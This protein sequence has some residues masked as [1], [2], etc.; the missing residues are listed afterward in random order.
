MTAALVKTS[1]LYSLKDLLRFER[2]HSPKI[3]Q[4]AQFA[5]ARRDGTFV[6]VI[7]GN[8]FRNFDASPYT[9]GCLYVEHRIAISFA[10]D[11]TFCRTSLTNCT[12]LSEWGLIYV[13]GHLLPNES[14]QPRI[15]CKSVFG[16][17]PHSVIQACFFH[18]VAC[19]LNFTRVSEGDLWIR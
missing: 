17:S 3:I 2:F 7:H 1:R 8:A 12:I 10:S 15:Q 16:E 18:L 9:Q 5:E 19:V 6:K 14:P 4:L 13:G 11:A